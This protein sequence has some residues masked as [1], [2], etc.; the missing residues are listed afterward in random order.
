MRKQGE[1]IIMEIMI[2]KTAAEKISEKINGKNGYL[3]LIYDTEGCGCS[4]DGVAALRFE[5]ELGEDDLLIESNERPIYIEETKTIF[6]DDKM[7]I[8]FL[9][10]SNWFMLKSPQEI[11]NG[12]MSFVIRGNP[13]FAA[14]KFIQEEAD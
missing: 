10:S 5:S 6:F 7:T 8:D 2:T 3:K 13:I 12:H 11:I 9:P 1:K 14:I 4:V